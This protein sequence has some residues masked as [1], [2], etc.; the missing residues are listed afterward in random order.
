LGSVVVARLACGAWWRSARGGARRRRPGRCCGAV[1]FSSAGNHPIYG[2]GGL[3]LCARN[4]RGGSEVP[5]LGLRAQDSRVA[6]VGPVGI[7][8]RGRRQTW[9]LHVAVRTP[10]AASMR[11]TTREGTASGGAHADAKGAAAP[12]RRAR[13]AMSRRGAAW[14]RPARDCVDVACFERVKL[15]KIA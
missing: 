4:Y 15:Q 6:P 11:V 8:V 12:R 3:Q 10:R 9:G 14:R 13:C 1:R 2:R 5:D 7:G